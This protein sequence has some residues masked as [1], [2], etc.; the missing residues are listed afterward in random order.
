[1][2]RHFCHVFTLEI[3]RLVA[4]SDLPGA[5]NNISILVPYTAVVPAKFT[6]KKI[7]P[8][9]TDGH[10]RNSLTFMVTVMRLRMG[11]RSVNL[12]LLA[13]ETIN[14]T[15]TNGDDG[16]TW[17]IVVVRSNLT[18]AMKSLFKRKANFL[19]SRI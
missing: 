15:F 14:K 7:N 10:I 1:M 6:K 18:S 11:R 8:I 13:Q 16:R 5:C 17:V 2:G 3:S 19:M 4:A 12:L 9:S